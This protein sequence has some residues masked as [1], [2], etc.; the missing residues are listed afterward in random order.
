MSKRTLRVVFLGPPGSG[1]GTMAKILA[2]KVMV[3]HVAVGDLLREAVRKE[4]DLGK[5]A[6]GFIN[7]GKLVPDEL[8]IG[9]T[10]EKLSSAECVNGFILDGFPRNLVQ[11]KALEGILAE[12]NVQLD[13]VV[14]FAIPLELV[15]DRLTGRR[16]CKNCGA[17]YHIKNKPPKAE[18]ICDICGGELYQRKDDQ[19]EIIENRFKVY[20]E[21][22]APL[23]VFYK[24]K[25]TFL[26]IDA[27]LGI[28]E[29]FANLASKLGIN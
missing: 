7:A 10:R 29:V 6:A 5:K 25:G 26:E 19:K 18:S 20:E 21:Q 9:L 23:V 12:L 3:P 2:E 28:G 14:Y 24:D 15:I 17:V 8:S 4:S 11:A 16:S 22:T 1:K 27:S 13:A